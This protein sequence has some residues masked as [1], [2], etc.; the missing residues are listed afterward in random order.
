MDKHFI[1]NLISGIFLLFI[2]S[3]SVSEM[4]ETAAPEAPSA[5]KPGDCASCHEGKKVIPE[6]HP[7]TK[8]M[9]GK[10]CSMCHK[11][12]AMNLTNKIPLSHMHKLAGISCEECHEDPASAKP[13]GEAVC[14]KCHND[15]KALYNATSEVELNPHFSPHEGKISDCN[16]CHH[17]HKNSEN[18][19]RQCH[20]KE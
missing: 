19:C 2:I 15:M 6:K 7:D 16:R 8:A 18:Y 17:Q 9:T 14:K 3:C 13:A 12:G 5:P 10:Q 20:K 11:T 4:S 1:R